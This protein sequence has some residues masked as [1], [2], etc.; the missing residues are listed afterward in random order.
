MTAMYSNT[1]PNPHFWSALYL[2]LLAVS[3]AG[4]LLGLVNVHVA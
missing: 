1:T 2:A 3:A 4:Y